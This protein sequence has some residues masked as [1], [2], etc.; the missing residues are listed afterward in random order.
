M[1]LRGSG[2][3]AQLFAAFCLQYGRPDGGSNADNHGGIL[4]MLISKAPLSTRALHNCLDLFGSESVVEL[5]SWHVFWSA[6]EHGH[7]TIK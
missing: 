5:L 3:F 4:A 2:G 6:N 1:A 7:H